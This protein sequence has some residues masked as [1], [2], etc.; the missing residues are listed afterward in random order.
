[1]A[2]FSLLLFLQ[3]MQTTIFIKS[4]SE[5][6]LR[7]FVGPVQVLIIWVPESQMQ[8]SGLLP[9]L[10]CPSHLSYC[11]LQQCVFL[12]VRRIHTV[13]IYVN[14]LITWWNITVHIIDYI[15]I[16]KYFKF[17]CI[18]WWW[19]SYRV[20]CSFLLVL[21]LYLTFFWGTLN[22]MWWEKKRLSSSNVPLCPRKTGIHG[23]YGNLLSS[24]V[25]SL[26]LYSLHLNNI[27]RTFLPSCLSIR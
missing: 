7:P 5:S 14:H 25:F 19:L 9:D 16:F 1:M 26:F 6:H 8:E 21:S 23:C 15:S 2:R 22:V 27:S 3:D 18:C 4:L 11:G 20:Y 24:F 17:P 13:L 12:H 10:L